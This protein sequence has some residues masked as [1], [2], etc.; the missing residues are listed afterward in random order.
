MKMS[1]FVLLILAFG[2]ITVYGDPIDLGCNPRGPL[3]ALKSSAAFREA[4]GE[5]NPANFLSSVYDVNGQRLTPGSFKALHCPLFVNSNA[6]QSASASKAI[7]RAE[8]RVQT[9]AP[10]VEVAA[11]VQNQSI[12]ILSAAGVVAQVPQPEI[13][14]VGVPET[15]QAASKVETGRIETR[16]VETAVADLRP[17][18]EKLPQ[19]SPK[20][21]LE[22]P[23]R[24]VSVPSA[25]PAEEKR[26]YLSSVT[27]SQNS[28]IMSLA[29]ATGLIRQSKTAYSGASLEINPFMALFDFAAFFAAVLAFGL[30]VFQRRRQTVEVRASRSEL[31]RAA[32][33]G[34]DLRV[35]EPVRVAPRRPPA[36]ARSAKGDDAPA[37]SLSGLASSR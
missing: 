15:S 23:G 34:F 14:K 17:A 6:E 27:Q 9:K 18:H 37:W 21:G 24:A 4:I 35:Q 29:E 11:T 7:L 32:L 1:N 33:S 22:L 8:A 19:E 31:Y 2:T 36:V 3:A 12:T 26:E 13:S 25:T 20:S 10:V 30:L 5:A 28:P 16:R